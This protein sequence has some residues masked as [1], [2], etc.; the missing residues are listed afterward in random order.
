MTPPVEE[1]P[2]GSSARFDTSVHGRIVREWTENGHGYRDTSTVY[3]DGTFICIRSR[4]PTHF[5]LSAGGH[6]L[7]LVRGHPG[8]ARQ[9]PASSSVCPARDPSVVAGL[10]V[11]LLP[12]IAG[13]AL[14]PELFERISWAEK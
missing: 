8:L 9:S 3:E 5:P 4:I 2:A 12:D 11:V 6:A 1:G 14:E 10:R 13:H 7:K